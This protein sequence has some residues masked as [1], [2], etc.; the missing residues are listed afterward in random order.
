MPRLN[1]SRRTLLGAAASLAALLA[2]CSGRPPQYFEP[3][4]YDYLS[5]IDLNV[6]RI[7]IRDDYH[8]IE[9]GLT[10]DTDSPTPPIEALKAMARERLV[11]VGSSGEAI[12]VIRNAS[13][14]RV[15]D[16]LVGMLSVQLDVRTSEGQRVGFASAAVT[17]SQAY[18]Q[19]GEAD[20]KSALYEITK[21]MMDDFNVEFEY[22]IRHSLR[23]W[24]APAKLTPPPPA[25][26]QQPLTAPGS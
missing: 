25:V 1:L 16:N 24:L 22:E 14:R 9:D 17:R 5:K 26:Q 13:L 18:P 23:D 10:F 4:N 11:P 8:P 19:G 20:L 6:A 21:N 3:L 7:A 15:E 12:L 2:G